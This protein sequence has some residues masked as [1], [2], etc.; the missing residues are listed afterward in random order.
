MSSKRMKLL[1]LHQELGKIDVAEFCT[2][3]VLEKK[4]RSARHSQANSSTLALNTLQKG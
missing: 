1:S 2:F 4:T 3:Y